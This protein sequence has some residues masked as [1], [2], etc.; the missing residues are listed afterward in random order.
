M[1]AWSKSDEPQATDAVTRAAVRGVTREQLLQK[2]LSTLSRDDRADRIGAWVESAQTDGDAGA[3]ATSF[4]GAV[5]DRDNANVLPEWQCL[6]PEA[7]LPS[8]VLTAGRTV[9][10]EM[11]GGTTMI[12]PLVGL[13]RALWVPVEKRGHLHGVLLAGSKGRHGAMPKELLE[14]TAAELALAI[15]YEEE[16]LLAQ[17]RQADLALVRRI[18]NKLNAGKEDG[19]APGKMD[20]RTKFSAGDEANQ[21]NTEQVL[22]ELVENCTASAENNHSKT[23][24]GLAAEFAAIGLASKDRVTANGIPVIDLRWTSG[25]AVWISAIRSSPAAEIWRKALL[26]RRPTGDKPHAPWM[27][28]K[29]ARIIAIPLG[30]EEKLLGVLIAGLRHNGNSYGMLERLELRAALAITAVDYGKRDQET[31]RQV[32]WRISLLESTSE[33]TALLDADGRVTAISAGAKIMLKGGEE[34]PIHLISE[35]L[36]QPFAKLFQPADRD[37]ISAWSER[38]LYGVGDRRGAPRSGPAESP[39]AVLN[40]GVKVRLRPAIPAGGSYAAVSLELHREFDLITADGH[41]KAELLSVLEC[42]SEGV[43]LFDA[44]ENVRACNTRFLQLMGLRGAKAAEIATLDG[45]ISRI[46]EHVAEPA[47]FERRWRD[48]ARGIDG[49]IREE[50][51]LVWPNS[52]VVQRAARPIVNSRGRRLGRIEIYRDLTAQRGSQMKLIHTEKLAAL[53]QLITGIAHELSSPLTSILVYGQRLLQRSH[54]AEN[55]REIRKISEEAE[56]ASTILRQLLLNA[57]DRKPE[58]RRVALNQMVQQAM[59]VQQ[60]SLAN[61][62]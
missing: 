18:L 15:A 45:L 20:V 29:V 23:S 34:Q 32:A 50:L 25:E 54:T 9:E 14:A 24:S 62:N 39:E 1:R 59:E 35:N 57:Q 28:Q 26:D 41:T 21:G 49:G 58:L 42:V 10:Q 4:R 7:V 36:K 43:I 3:S 5:W 56:R 31:K 44:Q 11:E 8:E 17:E 48:L 47:S 61:E 53:G 46:S 33:A 40:N 27:R 6:S 30:A 52:R 37:R 51:E 55:N 19:V 16:H 13:R 12:G 2:A 22:R 60:A 38:T